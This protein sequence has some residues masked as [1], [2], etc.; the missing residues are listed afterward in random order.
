MNEEIKFELFHKFD[1]SKGE[2]ISIAEINANHTKILSKL[3]AG[4][5]YYSTASGNSIVIGMRRMGENG[6][7]IV[8]YEVTNGYKIFTYHKEVEDL[9]QQ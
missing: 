8:I 6:E 7:E 5:E 1:F 4:L 2:K 3:K 9:K